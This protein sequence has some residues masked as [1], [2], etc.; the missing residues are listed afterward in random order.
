MAQRL[1]LARA[2]LHDPGVLLLDEPDAELDPLVRTE[3]AGLL[4]DDRSIVVTT[5]DLHL[6]L[7]LVEDVAILANSRFV[8]A[9]PTTSLTLATFGSVYMPVARLRALVERG[10]GGGR[11]TGR[12]RMDEVLTD[13][14]TCG[15]ASDAMASRDRGPVGD[16]RSS[17]SVALPDWGS[18]WRGRG[19]TDH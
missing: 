8:F 12:R 17:E 3:L 5:H 19:P 14:I 4:G 7:T 9:A 16:R 15:A 2:L 18:P 13:W 11:R 10:D 6:A 1:S